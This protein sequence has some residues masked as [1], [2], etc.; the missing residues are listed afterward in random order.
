MV[1]RI[2][3]VRVHRTKHQPN[4]EFSLKFTYEIIQFT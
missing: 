1:R 4:Y 3:G 2:Y